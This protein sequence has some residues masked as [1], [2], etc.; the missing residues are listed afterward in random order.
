M[1]GALEFIGLLTAT[2]FRLAPSAFFAKQWK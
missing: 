1:N 2:P